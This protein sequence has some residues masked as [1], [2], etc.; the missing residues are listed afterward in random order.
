MNRLHLACI[1]AL[2]PLTSTLAV[3]AF[4]ETFSAGPENWR[5][6]DSITPLAWTATGG[7]SGHADA[8]AANTNVTFTGLV[9]GQSRLAIRGHAS[10][11]TS[12][13]A[14]AGNW[15][16]SGVTAFSIDVRHN[17]GA[18]AL[19]GLRIAAPANSPG[20]SIEPNLRLP[21]GE[22]GRLI[23]PIDPANPGFIT[24]GAGSFSNVFTSVGNVQVLLYAPEGFGGAPGPYT[25]DIDNP[26]L[27]VAG[28][29]TKSVATNAPTFDRW[30]YPFNASSPLG[31]R[32][33]ASSFGAI[34]P[35]FDNRDAQVYFGFLLTNAIPAGLGPDAYQIVSATFAA[36]M[37]DGATEYDP[38]LDP[39]T[40]YLD[41]TQALH[42]ADADL[43]RPMEL[44][45]AGWRSGFTPATFGEDGPFQ[46]SPPPWKNV[47]TLF[48]LGLRDG[49]LVDVSNSID[50]DG[51][52]T[53]G[54]DPTPFAIGTAPITPGDAIPLP[55]T[56][57]FS[58]AVN[59]PLIQAYLQNAL[60]QGILGLVLATLHPS[61][62]MGPAVFPVWDQKENVVGQPASLTIAYRLAPELS[63]AA[64]D[65]LRIV[66]WTAGAAPVLVE[67][68]TSLRDPDWTPLTIMARTNATGYQTIMTSTNI[69]E[70]YR[71]RLP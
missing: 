56:F 50:S 54:F 26:A 55:T 29:G 60:D 1:L 6:T 24:F 62:F 53:N 21:S 49:A 30:M 12:G 28:A 69:L 44:F 45:G 48:A 11:G 27:H 35:E 41:P 23:V 25:L 71:L 43:G 15:L 61:S 19:I 4:T 51:S 33:T 52:F 57:T 7:P 14:F 64:E 5:T 67:R 20:A 18:A 10:F 9:D 3:S 42:T 36:T 59:E 40:S 66:R 17:L 31:N 2:T 39:W 22:W 70:S 8:Y 32:P 58:L 34:D 63:G 65:D 46:A 38:T 68:A 16:T 47:R 37:S 13:G